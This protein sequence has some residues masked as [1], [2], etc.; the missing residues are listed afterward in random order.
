MITV[1][2]KLILLL[3]GARSAFTPTKAPKLLG[4]ISHCSAGDD[5]QAGV[6]PPNLLCSL[7]S[8]HCNQLF[9][10]PT[11]GQ[12]QP[13]RAQS[14][15]RGKMKHSNFPDMDQLNS[16]DKGKRWKHLT[17]RVKGWRVEIYRGATLGH[18]R[19]HIRG[20]HH[21]AR[22]K[23]KH[24]GVRR[25]ERPLGMGMGWGRIDL[26]LLPVLHLVQ[27]LLQGRRMG[28]LTWMV[29]VPGITLANWLAKGKHIPCVRGSKADQ[30]G[31]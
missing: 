7:T 2:P 11:E 13:A 29:T 18:A 3:Q 6:L 28:H 16:H 25:V 31:G 26:L 10:I 23:A 5:G 20:H 8:S 22:I 21:P 15:D 27:L 17:W 30:M 4:K 1:T 14:L 24:L 19:V 9:L 12:S